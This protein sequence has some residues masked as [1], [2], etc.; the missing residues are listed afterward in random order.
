[1]TAGRVN[2]SLAISLTLCAC[3]MKPTDEVI[4]SPPRPSGDPQS[5]EERREAEP[6]LT[7]SVSSAQLDVFLVR[8]IECQHVT[9]TPMVQDNDVR[10]HAPKK[11]QVGNVVGAAIFLGIGTVALPNADPAQVGIGIGLI[12]IGA[13]FAAAFISTALRPHDSRETIPTRP[14]RVTGGFHPCERHPVADAK[15][16]AHVGATLLHAVTRQ[17]G[18]AI[19]DL[20]PVVPTPDFVRSPLARVQEDRYGTKVVDVDL[21]QSS[22]LP[23][24]RATAESGR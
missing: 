17:D 9:V 21:T 10:Q 3:F 18:H 11:P 16:L 19:F 8:G 5:F 13:L 6:E 12:S 15:I 24:W 7:A 1:M 4:L 2:A 22:L 20:S 14:E 23:N